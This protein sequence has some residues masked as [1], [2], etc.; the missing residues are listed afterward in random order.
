MESYA[1]GLERQDFI[2]SPGMQCSSCAFFNEC[3]NWKGNPL[4]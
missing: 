1:E 4:S 3:R 2:P